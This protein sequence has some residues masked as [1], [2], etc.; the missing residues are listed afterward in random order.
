VFETKDQP[1]HP[2]LA[3]WSWTQGKNVLRGDRLMVDMTTGVSKVGIRLRPR[4]RA[5]FNPSGQ[6]GP[7]IP[8]TP[9]TSRPIGPGYFK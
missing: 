5:C 8:G 7:T 1:D 6:G 3:A 2:C 4:G 9:V